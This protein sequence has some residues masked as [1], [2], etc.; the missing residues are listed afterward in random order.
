MGHID[1]NH[2]KR[3]IYELLA[4]RLPDLR[5]SWGSVSED[6]RS[7]RVGFERIRAELGAFPDPGAARFRRN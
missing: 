6:P 7:H 3:M 1:E 4:E 5:A 2:T